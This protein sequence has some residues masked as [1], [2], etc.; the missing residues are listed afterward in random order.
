MSYG[1]TRERS[2]NF[3]F[4]K[5]FSGV[6]SNRI[7]EANGTIS[8]DAVVPR[9]KLVPC[10]DSMS[11]F[12]T[13]GYAQRVANGEI[14]SHPM[15][16][17][18]FSYTA[19][20]TGFHIRINSP[21]GS[22][23]DYAETRVLPFYFHNTGHLVTFDLDDGNSTRYAQTKCLASVKT[24]SLMGIVA[25]AEANKTLRMLLA[26]LQT[27]LP[28]LTYIRQLRKGNVNI[29]IA[30]SKGRKL[31]INGRDF[32]VPKYWNKGPGRLIKPPIGNVVIPVGQTVSASVL[33]FNLGV[34]PLMM[35][36]EAF[37]K[38]IPKTHEEARNTFR[39][40]TKSQ[41]TK[42]S[43]QTLGNDYWSV[44]QSATTVTELTVRCSVLAEDRFDVLSDFGM[45][46]NDVPEA[47]W[48]LIPFSFI[49]DYIVNIGDVLGAARA[50]RVNKILAYSTVVTKKQTTTRG[51]S[52]F[53]LKLPWNQIVLP[54]QGQEVAVSI[55]KTRSVEPFSYGFAYNPSPSRPVVWQNLLSLF[56]QE[57]A[58]NKGA[59]RTFY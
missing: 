59:R 9:S 11:D 4:A 38:D 5:S 18:S 20:D 31:L 32:G 39:S 45:S 23:Q 15:H 35:D 33:A 16:K 51:Y 48:E 3:N 50:H 49:A 28:A 8:Y 10:T 54:F 43:T 1:A 29:T 19:E 17:E 44:V 37:L 40:V 14:I 2:R 24:S 41:T 46:V 56:V 47:A 42:T 53:Q 27:I 36:L 6:Y 57:L 52:N 21:G 12:V 55:T 7:K 34:K 13:P 25:L 58:H 22:V 30:R 26:P